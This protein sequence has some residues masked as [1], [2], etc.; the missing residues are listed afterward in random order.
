VDRSARQERARPALWPP[1][2]SK[3]PG[4]SRIR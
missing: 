4:S 2:R 3:H 1:P